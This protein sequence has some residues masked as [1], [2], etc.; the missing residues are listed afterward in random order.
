MCQAAVTP[1]WQFLS[2]SLVAPATVRDGI[3]DYREGDT[4]TFRVD[5]NPVASTVAPRNPQDPTSNGSRGRL[6]S[7]AGG[8]AVRHLSEQVLEPD[9]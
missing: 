4:V 2:Q 9:E 3:A 1:D 7:T 5:L 8:T 6:H